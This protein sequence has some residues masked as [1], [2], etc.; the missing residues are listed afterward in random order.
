MQFSARA[1]S[2][3]PRLN[4]WLLGSEDIV[5]SKDLRRH[6]DWIIGKV[7]PHRDALLSLQ[8]LPD[9]KMDVSCVWWSLHGDGG[10]ALWPEQMLDLAELNLEMSIGFGYYGDEPA[11]G[12]ASPRA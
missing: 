9:V 2:H 8:Q 10:P 7:R 4:M 11:T 6:L 3:V 12:P 5:S 1:K